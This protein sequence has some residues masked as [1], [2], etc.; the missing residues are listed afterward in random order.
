MQP[1]FVL[2]LLALTVSIF[3][4]GQTKHNA[5]DTAIIE[6]ATPKQ[7]DSVAKS[8]SPVQG[9]AIVY[10]LRPTDFGAI[11][12]MN[13][14]CD[15]IHIGSTTAE[16]YVY[17]LVNPGTHVFVSKSENHSSLSITV[18]AGKIYYIKQQVKMGIFFAETK[19][20]LLDDTEGKKYLSKCKLSKDNVYSN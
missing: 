17:T 1:K 11:V 12:K 16:R 4:I 18:E 20:K 14:D 6:E 7:K 13:I 2:L 3:S 9:K 19:L 10:L 15:D 8:L 5:T